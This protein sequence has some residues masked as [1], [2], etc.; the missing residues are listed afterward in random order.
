MKTQHKNPW[1]IL[2]IVL[3][4]KFL[5]PSD[6]IQI[7]KRAQINDLMMQTKNFEKLVQTKLKPS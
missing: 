2:K 7:S 4:G 5:I 1:D 3:R 6:Y